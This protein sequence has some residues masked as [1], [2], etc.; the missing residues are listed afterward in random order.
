MPKDWEIL[1]TVSGLNR[2]YHLEV[3]LLWKRDSWACER[4]GFKTWKLNVGNFEHGFTS[5]SLFCL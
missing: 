3:G 5:G 4:K 1:L 2:P